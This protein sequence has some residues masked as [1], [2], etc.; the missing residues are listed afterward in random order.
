[1]LSMRLCISI[2][3]FPTLVFSQKTIDADSLDLSWSEYRYSKKISHHVFIENPN[4]IY[5]NLSNIYLESLPEG[6]CKYRSLKTLDISSNEI[7]T[8]PNCFSN[9]DSLS[10]LNISSFFNLNPFTAFNFVNNRHLKTLYLGPNYIYSLPD[11]IFLLSQ[12]ENFYCPGCKL[13]DMGSGLSK[14]TL[15]KTLDL[16]E[17]ELVIWPKEISTLKNLEI[18]VLSRNRLKNLPSE[19]SELTNLI[20]LDLSKN[21]Y[22]SIPSPLAKSSYKEVDLSSNKIYNIKDI[23]KYNISILSLENNRIINIPKSIFKN[24]AI[25]SLDL[26]NN[27]INSLPKG[28]KLSKS[29]KFLGLSGNKIPPD[30]IASLRKNNPHVEIYFHQ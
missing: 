14:L 12:L 7:K 6:V 29:M 18:L 17:N 9:L 5:L 15:L 3:F 16:T 20:L 30:E 24:A 13:K 23:D 2:L 8:L 1:M 11:S 19:F 10:C 27:L 22:T 25:E 21:N 4:L 26:S 28:L